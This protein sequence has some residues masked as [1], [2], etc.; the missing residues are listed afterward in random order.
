MKGF[1]LLVLCD[2]SVLG[3]GPF[4]LLSLYT[5]ATKRLVDVIIYFSVSIF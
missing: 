1:N 3:R 4:S 5:I 2:I